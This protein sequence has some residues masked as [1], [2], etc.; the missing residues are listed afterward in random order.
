MNYEFGKRYFVKFC[1][2]DT[3]EPQYFAVFCIAHHCYYKTAKYCGSTWYG[4]III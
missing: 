3:V 4:R 2:S 1:D